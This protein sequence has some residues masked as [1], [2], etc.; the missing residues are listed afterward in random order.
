MTRNSKKN[1][2]FVGVV[3]DRLEVPKKMVK[4]MHVLMTVCCRYPFFFPFPD[5]NR[6]ATVSLSSSSKKVKG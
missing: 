1:L 2:V 4:Q 5:P 3:K 6:A